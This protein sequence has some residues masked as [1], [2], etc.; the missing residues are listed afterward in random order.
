MCFFCLNR[1]RDA[2]FPA[3]QRTG[4][5]HQ[6]LPEFQ[7]QTRRLLPRNK[8]HFQKVGACR[9]VL[10]QS[11]TRRLLP[12]NRDFRTFVSDGYRVSIADATLASPQ[13]VACTNG[14]VIPGLFQSQTRRLLP[15]NI[16]GTFILFCCLLV[17]IADATLASPQPQKGNG[18][19]FGFCVSIADATLASPQLLV[20][21][22]L[23]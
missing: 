14:A 15:R 4:K 8:T 6:F 7:S 17:S 2:C 9:G 21:G 20:E 16:D 19:D 22:V 1:R 3:T 13:P 18:T 12:R 23:Q 11:Q 5:A 10:F